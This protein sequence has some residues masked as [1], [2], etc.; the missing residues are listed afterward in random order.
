MI[1]ETPSEYVLQSWGAWNNFTEI[2]VIGREGIFASALKLIGRFSGAVG[3]T[4]SASIVA[5]DFDTRPDAMY[6]HTSYG[7]HQI[8]YPKG[9]TEFHRGQGEASRFLLRR[10]LR[11]TGMKQWT[12]VLAVLED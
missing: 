5:R 2:D 3:A 10:R 8:G 7:T 12:M 1:T 4:E 6:G 11:I 9:H